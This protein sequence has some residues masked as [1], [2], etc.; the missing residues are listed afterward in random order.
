[1]K[2]FMFLKACGNKKFKRSCFAKKK[3]Q[4]NEDDKFK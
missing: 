3:M 4:G 2:R 1:M